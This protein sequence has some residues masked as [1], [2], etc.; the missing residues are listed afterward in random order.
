MTKKV[1]LMWT[2]RPLTPTRNCNFPFSLSSASQTVESRSH[3]TT[4][5]CTWSCQ[6]TE[7]SLWVTRTT[8]SSAWV[9]PRR[10]MR[11]WAACL[12]PR[13][14][15][16]S[17]SPNWSKLCPSNS[18]SHRWWSN[19][20]LL[21]ASRVLVLLSLN[22]SRPPITPLS[23]S[24]CPVSATSLSTRFATQAARI[25]MPSIS[26]IITSTRP[27]A[28]VAATI[29]S[30]TMRPPQLRQAASIR[31]SRSRSPSSRAE[32]VVKMREELL[33]IPPNL[34]DRSQLAHSIAPMAPITTSWCLQLAVEVTTITIPTRRHQPP[35]TT[36]PVLA[37][38]R[39]WLAFA[40]EIN[41]SSEYFISIQLV[42]LWRASCGANLPEE[43]SLI[44]AIYELSTKI[45]F[46]SK[47]KSIN[48]KSQ[49]WLSKEKRRV[50]QS[51]IWTTGRN[52]TGR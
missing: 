13:L 4:L 1:P 12:S 30:I 11:N 33:S 25:T 35:P 5:R 8:C 29:T 47:R 27:L 32:A 44:C 41:D 18:S 16:S 46:E 21:R 42:L 15:N 37:S 9:W 40:C 50:K 48:S 7:N 43:S 20:L 23:P 28:T 31:T 24:Y 38:K 36:S 34:V 26:R 6:R 14:S 52:G 3:R 19:L 49:V 17:S 22:R 39:P 10:L 45:I 2:G 51:N